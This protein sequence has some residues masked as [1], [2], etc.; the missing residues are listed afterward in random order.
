MSSPSEGQDITLGQD[1][2]E[3]TWI[4]VSEETFIWAKSAKTDKLIFGELLYPGSIP[5]E[6]RCGKN[7]VLGE[8][9]LFMRYKPPS[10]G[11]AKN[12]IFCSVACQRQHYVQKSTAGSRVFAKA[13]YKGRF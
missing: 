13:T 11:N 5:C 3:Q 8:Q 9:A 6:N 4:T 10:R 7:L 1:N 2:W 12:Y